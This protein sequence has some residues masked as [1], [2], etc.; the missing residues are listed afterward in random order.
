MGVPGGFLEKY[1]PGQFEIV[2]ISDK[3]GIDASYRKEG[4]HSYDRPYL[5]GKRLF[6]KVFIRH[7]RG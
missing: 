3:W 2:G 5:N 1:N 4:T 6:P 7:R